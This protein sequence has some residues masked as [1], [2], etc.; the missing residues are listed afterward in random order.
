M[1]DDSK[2]YLFLWNLI[3]NSTL[4]FCTLRLLLNLFLSCHP[5][6]SR[7]KTMWST[8]LFIHLIMHPFTYTWAHW[9]SINPWQAAS[10]TRE[11]SAT[12]CYPYLEWNW[13]VFHWIPTTQVQMHHINGRTFT[14]ADC[15]SHLLPFSLV[16]LA[17]LIAIVG[18]CFF[19]MRFLY[20]LRCERR[21][22]T[23][24]TAQSTLAQ[25]TLSCTPFAETLKRQGIEVK[26]SPTLDVPC[27]Y[28]VYRP[29]IFMPSSLQCHLTQ[30][31]R[32]TILMHEWGHI[33]H[34][35]TA[36][37]L[38]C[39][40]IVCLFWWIPTR[41][42]LQRLV[43]WQEEACDDT[44]HLWKKD[45]HDLAMALCQVARMHQGTTK[46]HSCYLGRSLHAHATEHRIKR[47]IHN[48]PIPSKGSPLPYRLLNILRYWLITLIMLSAIFGRFWTF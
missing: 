35:D 14:P 39:Q 6:S 26:L 28:G 42:A 17:V 8:F 41:S 34:R 9:G 23:A 24:L 46:N 11:I 7:A 37:L 13:N 18:A 2:A 10:G 30:E 4:A 21:L 33:H 44:V 38:I 15:L 3:I 5:F 40:A 12:F 45:P 25:E 27:A 48:L 36:L 43:V 47:L 31:E 20:V 16:Q 1:M 19:L 32:Q 22:Y 29:T